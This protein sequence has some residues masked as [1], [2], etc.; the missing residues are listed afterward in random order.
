MSIWSRRNLLWINRSPLEK[1]IEFF[2]D[3]GGTAD[4]FDPLASGGGT[5]SNGNLTIANGK[6]GTRNHY[7]TPL[8]ETFWCAELTVEAGA[9]GLQIGLHHC[10]QPL[11]YDESHTLA[12]AFVVATC[13]YNADGTYQVNFDTSGTGPT[14]TTGD[15]LGIVIGKGG[16]TESHQG[17]ALVA[18]LKNGVIVDS[19]VVQYYSGPPWRIYVSAV[20]SIATIETV[21]GNMTHAAAYQSAADGMFGDVASLTGWAVPSPLDVLPGPSRVT[22]SPA[23]MD[24]VATVES[25]DITLTLDQPATVFTTVT[26]HTTGSGTFSSDTIAFAIGD[27]VKTLRYTPAED[28]TETITTTNDQ[29]LD[30]IGS[31][32]MTVDPAP[33]PTMISLSPSSLTVTEDVDSTNITATLDHPATVAFDMTPETDG[34]GEFI[35]DGPITFD[36]GDTTKTFKINSPTP[37]VEIVTASNDGGLDSDDEVEVTVESAAPPDPA[38]IAFSPSTMTVAAGSDSDDITATLDHPATSA[39]TMDPLAFTVGFVPITDGSYVPSGSITFNIGD[40]TKTFKRHP[41]TP[42]TELIFGSTSNGL[43]VSAFVTLTVT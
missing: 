43:N 6:A 11:P 16:D 34:D 12:F 38:N 3:P 36:I 40:T 27:R 21:K 32:E 9:S 20:A 17:N 29:S 24:A 42:G 8:D 25:D 28:G 13:Y 15:K 18:F 7:H 23:T 41:V 4:T 30:D 22:I 1:I 10:G 14:Y 35:P 37:G 26:M 39:F 19:G 2:F 31:L 5:L 33:D